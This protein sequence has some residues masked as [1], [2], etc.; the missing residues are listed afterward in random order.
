LIITPASLTW[1]WVNDTDPGITYSAGWSYSSGRG[2]GD[3]QSDVH[4]TSGTNNYAQ[5]TFTGTGVEYITE[6]YSDE[7]NVEI[8]IDGTYQTTVNCNSATR[9]AQA[10]VYSNTGLAAGS[11]TIK[12]VKN[13]GTYTLLDAFAYTSAPVP[14]FAISTTPSSQT[15]TAGGGTSFTTTI[16]ATN[17]FGGNVSLSVSGLPTGATASFSPTSVAGSGSSTLSVSTSGSTPAGSYTLT[18][19]GTSGSL[20]HSN[21]VTLNVT[22]FTISASP[23]SQTVTAG[24]SAIYTNTVG[25]LNGFNGNVAL[26]ISGLPAGATASFSPAS[27]TGSGSSTLTITSTNTMASSTNTLTITGTS[28]S[29]VHT[30]TIT[31]IVNAAVWTEVNDTDAGITYSSTGWSYST[32]RNDGDYNNDAHYTKTAANYAQYTFTGTSV[33]YIT[34]TYSDEGNVDV[35]IDGVL[36]TT[37]NCNSSTRVG[38]VVMYSN[39]ALAYGSHTIKVVKNSGT[40]MLLDAFTYR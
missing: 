3:Y 11:H 6:T 2:Y 8:Y 19:A 27:V 20:A 14:D 40:Y 25:A 33:Q 1:T 23:S 9:Q 4:Y 17:G 31:L 10:V 16:S 38:Q 15:V 18:I 30:T 39:T 21:T 12:I 32:N 5:Y 24:A 36:Q 29:L 13:S 7:G 34:E 26:S 35:Y 22:D 37:V 28:S